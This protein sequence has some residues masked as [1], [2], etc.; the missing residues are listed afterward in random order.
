MYI[1]RTLEPVITKA[2]KQLPVIMVIGPR[3]VGKTTFLRHL[4]GENRTYVTLDDPTL[5]SLAK[6]ALLFVWLKL[7]CLS[8]IQ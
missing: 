6:P 3:Q 7:C 8:V 1:T 2:S 4:A 5:L